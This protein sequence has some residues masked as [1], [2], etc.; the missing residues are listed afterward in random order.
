LI[1][2]VKKYATTNTL[3]FLGIVLGVLFG[4]FFPELALEQKVIGTIFISF[5]KMLVVPLVFASIM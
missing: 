3:V 5:L 2:K 4:V 1:K